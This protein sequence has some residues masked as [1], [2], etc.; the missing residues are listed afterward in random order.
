MYHDKS[1]LSDRLFSYLRNEPDVYI[2]INDIKWYNIEMEQE[3][4]GVP[5]RPAQPLEYRP[6]QGSYTPEQRRRWPARLVVGA[7]AAGLAVVALVG[8][9]KYEDGLPKGAPIASSEGPA[10]STETPVAEIP[11][12]DCPAPTTFEIGSVLFCDTFTGDDGVIASEFVK[13]DEKATSD[14]TNWS[15]DYDV[16]SGAIFRRNNRLYSGKPR[17]QKDSNIECEPTYTQNNSG[18]LRVTTEQSYGSLDATTAFSMDYTI[19]GQTSKG[20][21]FDGLNMFAGYQD[22]ED[23]YTVS[24]FRRDGAKNSNKP[25]F[26]IK[27]KIPAEPTETC[28]DGTKAKDSNNGCYFTLAEAVVP[29]LAQPGD[30]HHADL[31]MK[32]TG[33]DT[34]LSLYVDGKQVLSHSDNSEAYGALANDRPLVD[35][36]FGFR[37]DNTELTIDNLAVY[38]VA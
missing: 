10:V 11:T 4:R 1:R 13:Q 12:A 36:K 30:T 25:T 5:Q 7:L 18:V 20:E 29:E 6:P 19:L 17:I 24:L 37:A 22:E 31:L 35:G 34:Y 14:C 38:T 15:D 23:T 27:R 26:V 33:D 32:S 8:I 2:D 21:A 3:Q 28:P 9:D 16:N